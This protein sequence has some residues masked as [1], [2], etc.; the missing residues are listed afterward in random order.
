MGDMTTPQPWERRTGESGPA[1]DAFVAYR[2]D[3]DRSL[4]AV[5]Q[6]LTKSGSLIRRWSV[7]HHWVER[8]CAW[9]DHVDESRRA[10]VVET[11]ADMARRHAAQAVAVQQ[12]ALLRLASIDPDELGPMDLLRFLVEAQRL[13]REARALMDSCRPAPDTTEQDTVVAL[14]SDP[15]TRALAWQLHQ[16][17]QTVTTPGDPPADGDRPE[18]AKPAAGTAPRTQGTAPS[19]H[20][21]AARPAAEKA[22]PPAGAGATTGRRQQPPAPRRRR[23]AAS[24][25]PSAS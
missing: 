10:A 3:P 20:P 8:A 24:Q 9:D 6:Q 16:S 19:D 21:A 23:S 11:A 1:F 22:A 14:L 25:R 5:A 15:T 17:A 4:R 7:R 18:G 12:K 2:D 13:E